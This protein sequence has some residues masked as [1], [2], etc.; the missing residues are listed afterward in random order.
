MTR[1]SGKLSEVEITRRTYDEIAEDYVRNLKNPYLGGSEAYH[2]MAVDR[3]VSLLPSPQTRTLDMGCG[4]GHDLGYL[5]A[6]K[7]NVCGIDISRSMLSLARRSS[8]AAPLCQMDMR[9]LNFRPESF[10]GVWAAHCLYHIPRRD[11]GQVINGIRYVLQ[12]RGAFF[13]SLK[14]GEGAGID[15]DRQA[16]S[17]PGKPRYY[18]LY[19]E[20]EV[21]EMLGGFDIVEWD[22][23]P[24]IYYGSA[25]LYVWS[26]KPA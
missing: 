19:T 6:K 8:P 13:C 11:I 20:S 16:V 25:W 23:K 2:E 15:T 4:F 24:E 5:L 7:L 12:A 3:F 10:G 17:Y 1:E 22:V 9:R 26:K 14:L 18:A 21:R